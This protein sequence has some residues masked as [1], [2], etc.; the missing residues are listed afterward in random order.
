M[1]MYQRHELDI[2]CELWEEEGEGPYYFD[3]GYG[4]RRVVGVRCVAEG[5]EDGSSDEVDVV[6]VQSIDFDDD[7]SIMFGEQCN[8]RLHKEA[9]NWTHF[10]LGWLVIRMFF[11]MYDPATAINEKDWFLEL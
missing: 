2:A 8:D 10:N 3:D 11:D 7:S 9:V 5:Y 1:K 6:R 4:K